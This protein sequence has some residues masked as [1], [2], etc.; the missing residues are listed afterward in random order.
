MELIK[1]NQRVY[2]LQDQEELQELTKEVSR[3]R[4]LPK[5]HIYPETGLMNDPNGLAYFNGKYHV[6]FQWYPFEPRH[7]LKHW[8]LT[9]ST[10]LVDW[11]KQ[12]MALVPERS[13]EKNG[14]YSGNAIQ[15]EGKLYLFYTA[16]YKTENG[17]IPKQAVAMMDRN[18]RIHKQEAPILDG[19]PAG[20]SGELRDPYVFQRDG[21]FWMLLGGSRFTGTAHNGFGEV[22]ALLLYVSDDLLDWTYQGP[23]DL[24]MDTGYMLECPSLIHVDGKDVLLLSPMGLTDTKT[25]ENRFATVACI[26]ELSLE[27]REFHATNIQKV[28]A[29]FDYYAPQ[30]FLGKNDQPTVTAWFGCGEP[31]YPVVE[32]WK[33]GLTFLHRLRVKNDHLYRYPVR[34]TISIFRKKVAINTK[35]IEINSRYYHLSIA[36]VTKLFVGS[37]DDYWSVEYDE[38]SH[39]VT[40]SREGL[41]QVIDPEYGATRTDQIGSL[42]SI[43]LFVDNSFVELFLNKG[44]VVFSFRVFTEGQDTIWTVSELMEGELCLEK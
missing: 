35:V 1:N 7:G 18:G 20:Y 43:D 19:A 21:R 27:R 16:N 11:S 44:E 24:P 29:G 2:S 31:S 13:F 37:P 42:K 41:K 30:A 33:H 22:G 32:N 34:E 38:S 15:H 10:D 3:S 5:Y 39:Q 26:G 25:H 14:C 9:T 12:E 6:F 40:V 8:G 28:D 36:E 23:I 17:K 4:F